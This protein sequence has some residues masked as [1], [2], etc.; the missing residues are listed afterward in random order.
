[1]HKSKIIVSSLILGALVLSGCDKNPIQNQG[2]EQSA[3]QQQGEFAKIAEAIQSGKG[4]HCVITQTIDD[5]E[6]TMEYWL[7]GDKM[8]I[9][10]LGVDEAQG[11]QYGQMISDGEYTYM[12]GDDQDGLKW[13]IEEDELSEDNQYEQDVPEFDEN[14]LN[15]YEQQG[16]KVN[17]EQKNL[18]DGDFIPPANVQFQSMEMMMNNAFG[19][20]KQE[21]LQEQTQE[22][23]DKNEDGDEPEMD[24]EEAMQ[25]YQL[26]MQQVQEQQ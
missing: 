25:Q 5:Q 8:K 9:V 26:M 13:K 12:W 6:H 16:F 23:V 21:M 11:P 17:C 20:M 4:A 3:K 19:E 7:K 14:A 18:N 24:Q 2:Q 10:G 1:M 22:R 15:M